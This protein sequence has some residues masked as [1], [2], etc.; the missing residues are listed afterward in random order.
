M[1]DTLSRRESLANEPLAPMVRSTHRPSQFAGRL[2]SAAHCRRPGVEVRLAH[3]DRFYARRAG[4]HRARPVDVL[5][6]RNAKLL[7]ERLLSAIRGARRLAAAGDPLLHGPG[8]SGAGG[9][10]LRADGRPRGLSPA[11]RVALLDGLTDGPGNAR[12]EPYRRSAP[13]GPEQLLGHEHPRRLSFAPARD[14][15]LAKQ[16]GNRRPA[17]RQIDD[18]A[19]PGPA[20]RGLHGGPLGIDLVPRP[21]GFAP[22]SGNRQAPL[23]VRERA[24]TMYPW[25]G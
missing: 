11:A 17:V 5:Q 15:S 2:V 7:G 12:S 1:P 14:R 20:R 8:D 24:G 13:L 21:L 3:D 22:R 9:Y 18:H 16:A 19:L 25:S 4:D 10:L 6:C 23:S